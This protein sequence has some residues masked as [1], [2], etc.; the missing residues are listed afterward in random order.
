MIYDKS[1]DYFVE[2]GEVLSAVYLSSQCR[3]K[4]R[5]REEGQGKGRGRSEIARRRIQIPVRE[6]CAL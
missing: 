4:R 2:N 1:R 6:L 3:Y 5:K